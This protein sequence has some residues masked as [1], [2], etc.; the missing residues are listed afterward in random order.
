MKVTVI[1]PYYMNI[2]LLMF[3][4]ENWNSYSEEV[5]K[6]IQFII[7]D[8]GSPFPIL[9]RKTSKIDD[10]KADHHKKKIIEKNL[11]DLENININLKI[12]RIRENLGYNVAGARNL[13]SLM[14]TTDWIFFSDFDYVLPPEA[15]EKLV[16]FVP[17]E[18]HIYFPLWFKPNGKSAEKHE[19]NFLIE[20]H[21]F[22]KHGGYDEDFSGFYAYEENY[23]VSDILC[24]NLTRKNIQDFW[25]VWWGEND[26]FKDAEWNRCFKDWKR[27]H[28]LW[29]LKSSGAF[30]HSKRCL[31]F[32]WELW[33]ETP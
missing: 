1:Y 21:N 2:D 26:K 15:A 13:G 32:S 16:K 28:K 12:Y 9:S 19:T 8:D 5:R 25:V 18:D 24:K 23:F 4:V 31:R 33:Y 29:Q 22:W 14:A 20:K 11:I 17:E 6:N 10:V 7:V 3:H 30:P 27:N